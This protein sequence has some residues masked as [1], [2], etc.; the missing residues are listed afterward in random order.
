MYETA[1]VSSG[2]IPFFEAAILI[3]LTATRN[4]PLRMRIIADLPS[5]NIADGACYTIMGGQA[6]DYTAT[7]TSPVGL[8]HAVSAVHLSVSVYPNPAAGIFT[9]AG[10]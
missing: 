4:T 5:Y 2:G 3:P 7:I 9:V 6:E 10:S 1:P 8:G